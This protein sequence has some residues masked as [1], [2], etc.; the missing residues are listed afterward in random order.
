MSLK[1]NLAISAVIAGGLVSACAVNTAPPLPSE[2]RAF[3]SVGPIDGMT[4]T[5]TLLSWPGS[6]VTTTFTGSRLDAIITDGGNSILDVEINGVT[7]SMALE[8]GRFAYPIIDDANAT[9]DVRMVLRSERTPSPIL[10][11]GFDPHFGTIDIGEPADLQM[12]VIGDSIS[13]GYGV[14]GDSQNCKYSRETQNANLAFGAV[15]GRML[16]ADVTTIAMSGRGLTRNWG[17][18][19]RATM[20]AIYNRLMLST[21]PAISADTNMDVVIVH[22][23]TN[24]F[25]DG[26]PGVGFDNNYE[27]FLIRLR[28]DH[29]DA[30]LVAGWGPMGGADIYADAQASIMGAVEARNEAGDAKV[31][32]VSFSN[33]P[34]GQTYGCDYHPSADTQFYMGT[35][36]AAEISE[37]LS[38]DGQ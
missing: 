11:A 18:D 26:D 31:R 37:A 22:L 24:D 7:T 6:F 34:D 8:K 38:L 23:G 29:P 33:T 17:G 15:A 1:K 20:R 28:A 25:S 21:P 14:E 35:I 2:A 9:Y 19:D 27:D 13:T 16:D 32:F 12:L 3:R 36:L 30:L 5:G 4:P 10:F